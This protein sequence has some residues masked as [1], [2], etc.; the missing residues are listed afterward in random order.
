MTMEELIE[1][2]SKEGPKNDKE[3]GLDSESPNICQEGLRLVYV[4]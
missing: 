4:I 2:A 1:I 3:L